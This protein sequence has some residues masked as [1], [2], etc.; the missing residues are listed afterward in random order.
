MLQSSSGWSLM[1]LVAGTSASPSE[2][3]NTPVPAP[4]CS[5]DEDDGGGHVS[6]VAAPVGTAAVAA[7]GDD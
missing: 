6:A 5:R 2:R 4:P 1:L 7:P 3:P